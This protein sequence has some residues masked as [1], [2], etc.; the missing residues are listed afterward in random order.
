[1]RF[2]EAIRWDYHRLKGL[3]KIK[4]ND[5]VVFNF[6]A[7]DTVLLENQAV[8]YYD[9]LR[10]YEASFGK[11][12]GLFGQEH[13]VAH[14][15]ARIFADAETFDGIGRRGAKTTTA[16]YAYRRKERRWR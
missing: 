10:S 3:R 11:E 14:P 12:E 6:P 8:T 2:S 5:V 13:V 7:G 16:R 15:V 1:M 4:R 9:V